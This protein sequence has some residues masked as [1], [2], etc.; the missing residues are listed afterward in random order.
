MGFPSLAQCGFRDIGGATYTKC[1]ALVSYLGVNVVADASGI[2]NLPAGSKITV[3]LTASNAGTPRPPLPTSMTVDLLIDSTSPTG[4]PAV[5]AI[6]S[7]TTPG[8]DGVAET[9]LTSNGLSTG[10]PL[11][12]T[13]RIRITATTGTGATGWTV[14]SDNGKYGTAA[15]SY[16]PGYVEGG[17]SI[18]A[19]LVSTTTATTTLAGT[20]QLAFGDTVAATTVLGVKPYDSRAVS[21]ALG[22]VSASSASAVALG[23]ATALGTVDN[24]FANASVALKTATTFPSS[25]LTGLPWT[26]AVLTEA[27][28]IMDPRFTKVGLVQANLKTFNTPP[29]P[30]VVT[31]S[32]LTTDLGFLAMRYRNANGVGI[33][34][35]SVHHVLA[36]DK[37]LVA[38]VTWKDTTA[39]GGGEDGWTN[40]LQPWSAALPGGVWTHTTD[41]TA[42]ITDPAGTVGTV[43]KATGLEAGTDTLKLLARDFGVQVVTAIGK[44]AEDDHIHPGD[45]LTVTVFAFDAPSGKRLT[46]DGPLTADDTVTIQTIPKVSLVRLVAGALQALQP[47]LT[48][49]APWAPGATLPALLTTKSVADPGAWTLTLTATAAWGTTDLVAVQGLVVIV[50]GTYTSQVPREVLSGAANGHGAYRFDGAGFVG[51]P[52]K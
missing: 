19:A 36:D 8:T 51:F 15:N 46:V 14:T 27:P 29:L 28:V 9:Y 4:T 52:S 50:G 41:V 2:V 22:L 3:V 17:M 37:G 7:F 5:P 44:T 32:R 49:W 45:P 20:A 6:F 42:P 31:H 33:N 18:V 48:T 38:Q 30:V 23:Y 21:V 43:V 24:R 40:T 39:S 34:G 1:T 35:L 26:Q 12:G 16:P 47:D 25:G 13:I 11:C 10:T